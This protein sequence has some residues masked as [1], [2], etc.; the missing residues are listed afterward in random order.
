MIWD[1]LAKIVDFSPSPKHNH[2]NFGFLSISYQNL[3]SLWLKLPKSIP[4]HRL[5]LP[6][7]MPLARLKVRKMVPL[8]QHIPRYL[9]YGRPPSWVKYRSLDWLRRVTVTKKVIKVL[10][11]IFVSVTCVLSM[12]IFAAHKSQNS[13]VSALS[14]YVQYNFYTLA[15]VPLLRLHFKYAG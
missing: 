5:T 11:D 7:H 4:L 12:V 2:Q 1:L 15:F 13:E 8:E 10:L 6:K 14:I 3:T 9:Y